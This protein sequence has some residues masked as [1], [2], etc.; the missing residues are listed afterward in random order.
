[1]NCPHC[2]A[3][4]KEEQV[5]CESC[6]KE[7]QL[8]PVFDAEIDNA[9]QSTMS[10]IVDDLANT[11]EIVPNEID[12]ELK[13]QLMGDTTQVVPLNT[14]NEQNE[15]LD[16]EEES[17]KKVRSGSSHLQIVIYVVGA[18]L[19][20]IVLIL[21]VLLLSENKEDTT[22]YE[23]QMKM[24]EEMEDAG[25][26]NKMLVYAKKAVSSAPNSSDAKM[27]IAKAYGG[28]GDEVFQIE[29]LQQLIEADHAYIP[30]YDMLIS[31]YDE[32]GKYEEIGALLSQCKEQEVLDKYVAYQSTPPAF[33]EEAG[34]YTEMVSL[35]LIA[36]GKGDVYYTLDGS[37][38][39]KNGEL[40]RTPIL[41]GPGDVKVCAYY[42]NIYG[43]DSE[44]VSAR[45]QIFAENMEE[46]VVKLESGTYTEPQL[47][48]VEIPYEDGQVYYTMDGSLPS[49]DSSLY[50]RPIPLPLGE[51][52][53]TFALFKED[54]QVSEPISMSYKFEPNTSLTKDQVKNML[55]QALVLNHTLLD[56]GGHLAET[57]GYRDYTVYSATMMD[58]KFCYLLLE[59]YVSPDG[60][61][62]K[63]GRIYGVSANTGECYEA[64]Q[65]QFGA[66][67]MN[68]L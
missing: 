20:V 14:D 60:T 45:Y 40:Y 28:L 46:P 17:K 66:F 4:M 13:K 25:E 34:E 53:F 57:D 41:L 26:Y 55:I 65:D 1:M 6:G 50:E 27:M 18:L 51:S 3:L 44:I 39:L 29:V 32:Q 11:Q 22:S 36:P 68:K 16:F 2:G 10:G 23:H 21:F 58:G 30:A 19:V 48:E 56:S 33:S 12:Q 59:E 54:E 47:I 9:L 31:I 24:A 35:K 52:I 15:K 38:P 8:V 61:V 63:T 49:V 67:E 42:K 37:D 5:F 62:Q 64:I 7:R 43:I